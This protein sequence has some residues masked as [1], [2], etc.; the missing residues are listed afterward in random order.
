MHFKMRV[1]IYRSI[2]Q[3]HA[4]STYKYC[5]SVSD[6]RSPNS[7]PVSPIPAN[8]L[9]KNVVNEW[10]QVKQ[11]II[12][13]LWQFDTQKMYIETTRELSQPIPSQLLPQGSDPSQLGGKL[14]QLDLSALRT[15]TALEISIKVKQK[16]LP[17]VE[18]Y[19]QKFRCI[20][21]LMSYVNREQYYNN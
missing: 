20:I 11:A 8:F 3:K 1:Q 7:L 2:H 17:E 4:N 19:D 6:A 12:K 16:Q 10:L 13:F 14:L 15:D 18:S 21:Q 9:Q 5:N